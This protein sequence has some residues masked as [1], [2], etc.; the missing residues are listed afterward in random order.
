MGMGSDLAKICER[1]LYFS[2]STIGLS[3]ATKAPIPA[4]DLAKVAK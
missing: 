3:E 1:M 4:M 2:E